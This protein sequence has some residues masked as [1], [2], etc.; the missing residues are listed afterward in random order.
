MVLDDFYAK[1]FVPYNWT[2]IETEL[3]VNRSE[4][5]SIRI[6]VLFIMKRF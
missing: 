1:K 3:A 5:K 4:Y 6:D 2:V